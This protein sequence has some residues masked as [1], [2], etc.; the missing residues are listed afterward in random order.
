[1]FCEAR[2]VCL[3]GGEM[4]LQNKLRLPFVIFSVGGKIVKAFDFWRRGAR[5][6]FTNTCENQNVRQE[7][8]NFIRVEN[9]FVSVSTT[10]R[11]VA[12]GSMSCVD[13]HRNN[14]SLWSTDRF[15]FPFETHETHGALLSPSHEF[16]FWLLLLML[17]HQKTL[18]FL[19]ID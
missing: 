14:S 1:M 6:Y 2:C 15:A 8:A 13:T 4:R 3:P 7:K 16:D 9:I 5:F 10:E 12:Q 11:Q 18:P 17:I 19:L